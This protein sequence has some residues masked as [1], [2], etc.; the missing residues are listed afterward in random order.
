MSGFELQTTA[1]CGSTEYLVVAGGVEVGRIWRVTR[2]SWAGRVHPTGALG[3]CWY[4]RED[5][6]LAVVR[7]ATLDQPAVAHPCRFCDDPVSGPGA[8]D[9]IGFSHPEC[10]PPDDDTYEVPPPARRETV[11]DG[12]HRELAHTFLEALTV[13]ELDRLTEWAWSSADC[14]AALDY[15]REIDQWNAWTKLQ[16]LLMSRDL[17]AG[18]QEKLA[19]R[20]RAVADEV[21]R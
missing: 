8:D 5:A 20:L 9:G 6:A 1:S 7:E 18:Q 21:T 17:E 19:E 16:I 11:P 14:V 10:V 3:Q 15:L 4:S 2:Y 12:R 13:G